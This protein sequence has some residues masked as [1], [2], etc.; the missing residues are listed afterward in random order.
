MPVDAETV[1]PLKTTRHE[2]KVALAT[3]P[4][5]NYAPHLEVET[6]TWPLLP[7]ESAPN[8]VE[9]VARELLATS[10]LLSKE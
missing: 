5:L 4:E 3:I 6:Y 8:I 7:Q 2:L 10:K 1:G 9:G